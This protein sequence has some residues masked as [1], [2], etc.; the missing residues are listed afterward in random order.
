VSKILVNVTGNRSEPRTVEVDLPDSM[1]DRQAVA[2]ELFGL[3]G[4]NNDTLVSV[5]IIQADQRPELVGF[6]YT[7][8]G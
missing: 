4:G 1:T 7:W 2:D 6:V 8:E 5:G 3:T